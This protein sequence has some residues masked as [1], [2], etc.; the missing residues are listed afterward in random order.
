MLI[1]DFMPAFDVS[2]RH[3]SAV[4]ASPDRTY[5]AMRG[6]DF[7]RSRLTLALFAAR[8]V[9][10][11]AQPRQARQVY[12][13]LFRRR[14]LTLDDLGRVGF[15]VLGELP[16]EEIVLGVVGKFWKPGS[17]L[18]SVEARDFVGFAEPGYAKGVMNFAVRAD[19]NGSR[20][21]TETRVFCLDQRSRR[22]FRRYW[23]LIRPFS[24]LIRG[25]ALALIKADAERDQHHEPNVPTSTIDS[26]A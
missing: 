6:I 7:A 2:E 23:G 15:V 4:R 24:A 5:R 19:G 14:G 1:D 8:A 13:S 16:G 21:S 20:V 3:E 17:G 22:S 12:G 25:R 26:E 10:A 9:I 18:R 11:L